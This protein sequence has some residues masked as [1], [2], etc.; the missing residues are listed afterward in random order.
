MTL[1]SETATCAPKAGDYGAPRVVVPAPRDPRYAH[2]AWPKIVKAPDG[3]LVLAYIAAR[4]HGGEGCPSVSIS[5]DAGDTF[6]APRTL[7]EFGRGAKYHHSGNL[8]LGVA[9]D[10]AVVLLTMAFS[11]DKCNSI[12]GWRSQD[13]GRTWEPVDTSALADNKT[14]SVFGH[15]FAVPGKGLA[16]A[17]H[18][19]LPKGSGIWLAYSSDHGRTWGPPQTVTEDEFFEPCFVFA[20]GRLIGLV[21]ENKARAYHQFV[22]DDLGRTWRFSSRAV[23]G[24]AA[25]HPSPFL[26]VDPTG[27]S[28][29]YCLQSQRTKRGEMVLWSADAKQLAWQKHGL[30]ASCP[31]CQDYSYPWMTHLEGDKWF[32]V[33]YAGKRDGAN[34]I[35]GMA[36]DVRAPSS[37]PERKMTQAQRGD[38]VVRI[39][40]LDIS[41]QTERHVVVAQGTND[42]YQGHPTTLLMP[43]GKTMFYVWSINHGGPCGPLKRSDDGGK[44]WSDLLPVPDNW[45]EARNCPAIYRLTDPAGAARLI[46]FAGQ[47]PGGQ[48][49]Q[50][51]SE[52]DGRTWTRMAPNGL[53][54]VMPFCTIVPIH[55]GKQLLGMTNIRRPHETKEERSNVVA[56]SLSSDGGM[57]W[58]DWRIVLDIPGCKP[59]EP[60][61]VRSP[62]GKQLLCLMRENNR[63]F[64]AWMMTSDDEG[65]TWPPAQPLPASLSG[66]RHAARY[67]ADGRLVVCFRDTAARSHTRDHF[68][69]WVG[70]YDDIVAGRDGHYRVKLLHSY[71]AGDCGYPGLEVLPDGT[72][73]ATTYIKYKP[74]TEKHSVV[75][76]RFTLDEL[77]SMVRA[78][79]VMSEHVRS[80]GAPA[81]P[82]LAAQA[83]AQASSEFR[84]GTYPASQA[85]DGRMTLA[86]RWVSDANLPH[87]LT[88]TW[89]EDK[90]IQRVRVFSGYTGRPGLAVQ[91]YM[92][93]YW[94][95]QAW[96]VAASV[97]DSHADGP[98]ACSDSRFDTVATSKLKLVF[99]RAPNGIA[100]IFEVEAYGPDG[101]PAAI[102]EEPQLFVDDHHIANRSGVVRRAHACRKLPRPVIEA[103]MPWEC[104][105][106]DSRVYIYGTVL[107]DPETQQLRMWYNRM[108]RVLLATSTDGVHWTRPSLGLVDWKGN[109]DNNILPISMN[110]PSIIYDEHEPDQAKRYKMLGHLAKGYSVAY[111]ADGLRWTMYPKNP[112]LPGGDTCTLA[113]D[114]TTHEYLAFHKLSN[115]HRGH[116]RRLVYL[117]TSKDMQQW[118]KPRLVMAP[119]EIDDA[120]A[121][122]EGGLYSQFYNMSCFAYGRQMLGLVTHFQFRGRPEKEGPGQS[123]DDGPIDVQLVHSRDGRTWGR[124]E[125]RVPVIPNGPHG[126]D[127]GCIL[128]TANNP[129][130]A[131]DEMWIY[132]TAITTTHGGFLPEKKITIARAAWRLDGF[133]SLDAGDA[134]GVVE[135]VPFQPSGDRLFVNADASGGE[136]SVEVLDS[137]GQPSEGY[138]RGDCVPLRSDNVHHALRWQARDRLPAKAPIRLRFHFKATSLYSYTVRAGD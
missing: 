106:H 69:A 94:D 85:V 20:A 73:A 54:C 63:A 43:D 13:F 36:L 119:D 115:K 4:K 129:I 1:S 75:S 7:M 96:R 71:A 10:G 79:E 130:I 86:G 3:T 105:E 77:D 60:C 45:R 98:E 72:L 47:G 111:S 89:D 92:I 123:P 14:G 90:Q 41:G 65:A 68:V 30:V 15:V 25:G 109:K 32:V 8:A 121:K 136:L 128:G 42:V 138:G 18:Y 100:R 21:R 70:T 101:L 51:C 5:T 29:L 57:T 116:G 2:L 133:V 113:Q 19:R 12:F 37:A 26:A 61:L 33:F 110:S 34:S 67:A 11:G 24:A 122:I 22:S 107:R 31:G 132:Y 118:S 97:T 120:Q 93:E 78:G 28:R 49:H 117:S 81:T 87:T 108:S 53:K 103:E 125:H 88:L 135:T 6:T 48:M 56:Q 35:Y 38:P 44:T 95:G 27:P 134:S 16:V 82:N 112:V 52:D 40:T 17:G 23:A 104:R 80:V 66:D 50:A 102:G 84:T 58:S 76:V 127:A 64:N 55:G 39:P 114:P 62:D 99:A 126:Y 91:D 9:P 46:V 137:E 131:G 83:T 124:C 59:C 74:G